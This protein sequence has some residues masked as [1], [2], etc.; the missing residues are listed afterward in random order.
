MSFEEAT[1]TKTS[2]ESSPGCIQAALHILGDKWT[3]LLIGQLVENKRTFSD[4]E[5]HLTGISP[6]TLSARLDKL[7]SEGIIAKKQYSDHP[8]RFSYEL[9]GKG[10]GLTD[11]LASMAKWGET[12]KPA[13]HA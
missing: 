9:T 13:D 5:K 11:I 8:Q 2:V 3:P 4:L 10:R 12:H 1:D 7:Q 6:R